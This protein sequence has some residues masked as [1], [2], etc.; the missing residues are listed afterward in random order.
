MTNCYREVATRQVKLFKNISV[1]GFSYWHHAISNYVF[2]YNLRLK[3]QYTTCSNWETYVSTIKTEILNKINYSPKSVTSLKSIIL[4]LSVCRILPNCVE[5]YCWFW[6]KWFQTGTILLC[7]YIYL[8]AGSYC[9]NT[10][11]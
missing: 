10:N 11:W 7:H 9:L 6:I 5:C 1:L 3:I 2:W 8:D 4:L